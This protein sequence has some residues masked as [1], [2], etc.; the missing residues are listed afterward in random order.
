MDFRQTSA[1]ASELVIAVVGPMGSNKGL[2][3]DTMCRLATHHGYRAHRIGMSDIIRTH[4]TLPEGIGDEYTRVKVLIKA[5]NELRKSAKDNALL[6]KMSA[7]KIA[8]LRSKEIDARV[9]YIIDSI[10]HPEEVQELRDIYSGGFYLFA[11]HSSQKSREAFLENSCHIKDKSKREEL[12]RTDEDEQK[13]YGQ[14]TREAFH[15]ADFFVTENGNAN[16]VWAA[17]RRFFDLIFGD[18]FR[19]PTFDEYAMF[20]AHASSMKSADMSRQVGAVVTHDSDI[21]ASGANECPRPGGG[22]YWPTFDPQSNVIEDVE[23]GRDH[24]RNEDRNAK[25]KQLIVDALQKN[26]KEESLEQLKQNIADSG[27]NDLTEYGRVVH[28]EMDAIL[29]CARRGQSCQDAVLFC[30]TFPCHNC[31]KHIV[32]SGFKTVVYIEPYPKSKALEMHSDSIAG[33]DQAGG[34]KVIFKPFVGVGPRQFINLFSL[35]LGMGEKLRRKQKS[36][37]KKLAWDR[38]TSN[39]RVR[40]YPASYK[41]RERLVADEVSTLIR[42]LGRLTVTYDQDGASKTGNP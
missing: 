23:K 16:K 25:E 39:P 12:I 38:E 21:I 30:T 14:S 10:K 8:E 5:G 27:L 41:D 20:M 28:A 3:I 42:E 29:S 32:A 22:T 1:E 4:V 36:S 18:P 24:T 33:P 26:I 19:T 6:A 11:V 35:T 31:A 34:N 2:V 13:G 17:L 37:Y 7:I 40:M 9:I 15:L